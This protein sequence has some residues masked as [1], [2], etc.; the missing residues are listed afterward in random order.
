[1]RCKNVQFAGSDKHPK[2]KP[3]EIRS[4]RV[5][6]PAEVCLPQSLKRIII[7]TSMATKMSAKGRRQY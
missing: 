7:R 5:L 1:M 4:L 6:I 3:V 2:F